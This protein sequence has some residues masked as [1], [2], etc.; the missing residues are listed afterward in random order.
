MPKTLMTNSISIVRLVC[1]VAQM[2]NA[3]VKQQ[4]SSAAEEK[5]VDTFLDCA[6]TKDL[7]AHDHIFLSKVRAMRSVQQ[8]IAQSLPE[9]VGSGL[10]NENL[11][12]SLEG[13][14]DKAIGISGS[15]R[16]CVNDQSQGIRERQLICEE[17]D[18]TPQR[19][20]R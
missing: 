10:H 11:L 17:Q 20:P 4:Q 8:H 18:R 3:Q 5:A 13:F 1:L 19:L 14:V 2:R 7:H 16:P 9:T 15:S 12:L 6:P